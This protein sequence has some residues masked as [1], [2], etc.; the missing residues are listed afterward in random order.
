MPLNKKRPKPPYVQ[1]YKTIVERMVSGDGPFDREALVTALSVWV[2]AD[3]SEWAIS[4]MKTREL[5]FL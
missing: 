2:Q 5:Y 4:L 1:G 3:F